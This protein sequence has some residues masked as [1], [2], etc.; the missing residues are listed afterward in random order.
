M[1]DGLQCDDHRA[2]EMER[3]DGEDLVLR[4]VSLREHQAWKVMV[5]GD[6]TCPSAGQ[7]TK[8]DDRVMITLTSFMGEAAQAA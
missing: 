3:S 1:T 8:E 5:E 2:G 6:G 7:H 4:M